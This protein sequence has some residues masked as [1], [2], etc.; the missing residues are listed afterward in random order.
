[1]EET[2]HRGAR[3][4]QLVTPGRPAEPGCMLACLFRQAWLWSAYWRLYPLRNVLRQAVPEIE[5][6]SDPGMRWNIRY[7][8]YRRVIE[9]RDAQLVLRP[10]AAAVIA[11]LATAIALESGLPPDRV[12]AVAEAAII[13]SALRSRARGPACR[14]GR[15]PGDL[16][17]GVSGNDIRAEAA[18]VILVCRAI[19]RSPIV[20]RSAAA[21]QAGQRI[22][23]HSL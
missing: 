11:R 19:R 13:V 20:W 9:I 15:T 4:S 12:A 21:R 22:F 2:A 18:G 1:M 23:C 7:R 3:F 6:P 16:V 10:Y 5:L 17:G 8:L 14:H